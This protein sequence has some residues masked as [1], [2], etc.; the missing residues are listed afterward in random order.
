MERK[1]TLWR[2]DTGITLLQTCL[3][4][5]LKPRN[6]N[7]SG[8]VLALFPVE[9]I[10][11][12]V[13]MDKFIDIPDEVRNIYSMWRPTPLYRAYNLEKLDTPA[14]IYYKYEGVSPTGSTN[15]TQLLKLLQ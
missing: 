9:L 11:Q 1:I 7:R 13:S 6:L 12:E 15:P 10:K 14:K 5:L 8:P 3:S 2:L 4:L